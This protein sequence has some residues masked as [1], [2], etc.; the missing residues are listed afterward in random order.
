MLLL[1]TVVGSHL[2]GLSHAES[3]YDILEVHGWGKFKTTQTIVE[4]NDCIVVC[5]SKFMEMCDK[6]VPQMLEAMF[7]RKATV[8]N[9][10]FNRLRYRPNMANVREVYRRTI[11]NF[12]L[13][14]AEENDIKRI[15]HAHRLTM[16]LE[17]MMETG[18]FNPTLSE[19]Q[20]D[21]IRG[22]EGQ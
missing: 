12:M 21:L 16:N 17:E 10:P 6:G 9:M 8:D 18:S 13:T 4:N 1:R 11:K 22:R 5:Y 20:I 3:D 7:S 2:Y 19:A 14:G 15:R